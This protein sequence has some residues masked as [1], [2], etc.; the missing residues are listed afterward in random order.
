VR[1]KE[2]GFSNPVLWEK[3]MIFHRATEVAIQALVFLAQQA[4]GKLSPTHEIAVEAKVPEAYLAKVLQ[5]LG[6]AGLVRTFRGS[7]KGVELGKSAAEIRLSSV[8]VATQDSMDS[9][10][11]ILGLPICSEKNPCSLHHEWLPHKAAI[12]EMIE[13]TTVEDLLRSSREA[14]SLLL[15]SAQAG[16]NAGKAREV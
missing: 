2:S 9:D 8:V 16:P 3:E 5:R 10:R 11:C 13:R 7:G 4:P 12:Q 15:S 1:G 6:M 14:A